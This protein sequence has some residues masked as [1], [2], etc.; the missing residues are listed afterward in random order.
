MSSQALS[1]VKGRIL[2]RHT[3]YREGRTVLQYFIKTQQ[4]P[5]LIELDNAEVICF[6]RQTD[7]QTLEQLLAGQLYGQ[8][9][10]ANIKLK[11]F[12]HEPLACIYLNTVKQLRLVIRIA[13]DRGIP[14][15]ESDIKTEQRF[16]IERFIALDAEFLGYWLDGNENSSLE[17]KYAE[18]ISGVPFLKTHRVNELPQLALTRARKA[19]VDVTLSMISLDFECAMSGELYS[20]GL[21]GDK[22]GDDNGAPYQKVIMIGEAQADANPWI[23]WVND[24]RALILR[25]IT[26][27]AEY[28]PDVIIGWAVVTFDLALLYRRCLA[29][30]ITPAFGRHGQ[31]LS[32]KVADK[33]RPETLS[34]PGRVVLDGIDWLKAAFYQFERYSLEFVSQALLKEGKAID[35]VEN[36]AGEITDLFQNNKQAL[37]QYNITD[38]RLVWDIFAKTELLAFALERAKLTGLEFGRV[39]ASIAAFNHLYLPHLHRHGF[40]A[41]SIASSQGIESPG[42][43]VMDSVPGF[44]KDVLVLDFKSLYPSIIRTFLIDP[45]GL[46]T[47]MQERPEQ[48]VPGFLGASFSRESPILPTLIAS[49]A[50][51]RELAKLDKNNPLSHAIKIIM[52]SLYGVLGSKGCVFHDAKL[53]SSITMRGHEIMKQTRR[54]IEDLGYQVIYGDTDS[55]FVWLGENHDINNINEFGLN[56]AR[57][58]TQQWQQKCAEEFNI[59]SFLELEFE[60][61]YSQFVMPTLRGS[62]EG[63]KKRYVGAKVN[64]QGEMSLVFKGME[65]VR[66][67]WSPIA[68][69]IQY[70]LYEKLFTGEDPVNFIEQELDALKQ[71][72]R[73]SE[74]V[75]RKRLKRNIED[76][77]AKSSPHVKAAALRCAAT[78]DESFGRKGA[79]VEYVMTKQGARVIQSAKLDYDYDYYI[80]K[81]IQPIAEPILGLL[82]RSFI[83]FTSN[84]LPL[85]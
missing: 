71:G 25:L 59:E 28:D 76:Y 50:A 49:L 47:G 24:E 79:N 78:G 46:V 40:V 41:P 70:L 32:W 33:F 58:I 26:W 36:R 19:D 72:L 55:T 65:Q 66:S 52:N 77:T 12:H 35:H 39:G 82:N 69:R 64:E 4:G 6:C 30:G 80:E 57:Q 1:S 17:Q 14:L 5:A 61:H 38:C 27:F 2:T 20:V 56:I 37:A 74:L 11:S 73:N 21:Y 45:K 22:N 9:R 48:T 53:A 23:E 8:Y 3:L 84:Q 85:L 15:F 62:E 10:L 81:Q 68:R 34:L 75:F 60:T 63:S 29:L 54:W 44:Y 43:Y 18:D 42:G 7:L 67:D 83:E 51:Q 13:Q 16:L 31:A